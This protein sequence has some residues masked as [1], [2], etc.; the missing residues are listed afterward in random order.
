MLLTEHQL[1]YED[2][3]VTIGRS[4]RDKTVIGFSRLSHTEPG[5]VDKTVTIEVK[6]DELVYLAFLLIEEARQ[7]GF[8]H[9]YLP[10]MHS[11][12]RDMLPDEDE[13]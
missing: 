1:V 13:S 3:I 11:L 4:D 5:N 8:E 12:L 10:A 7:S 2:T 6:P 9:C